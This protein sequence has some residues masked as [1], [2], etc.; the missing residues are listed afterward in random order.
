MWHRLAIFGRGN[1]IPMTRL[2]SRYKYGCSWWHCISK[3]CRQ[4][5]TGPL[6]SP[7]LILTL[8]SPKKG[9]NTVVCNMQTKILSASVEVAPGAYKGQQ[10]MWWGSPGQRGGQERSTWETADVCQHGLLWW[11]AYFPIL[12]L[13]KREGRSQK[14][15]NVALWCQKNLTEKILWH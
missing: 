14:G 8:S 11:S 7:L 12:S 13:S 15:C 2:P 6:P 3:G 1:Q 10:R 9:T 5:H 4:P